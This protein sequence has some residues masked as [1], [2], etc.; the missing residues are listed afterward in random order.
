M[1]TPSHMMISDYNALVLGERRPPEDEYER[2]EL[3]APE[4]VHET[5]A[6]AR[7]YELNDAAPPG[8]VKPGSV[9]E[10]EALDLIDAGR[11]AELER[12]RKRGSR[13]RRIV[14]RRIEHGQ[15]IGFVS[16]GRGLGLERVVL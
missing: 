4:S 14:M 8:Y 5:L 15:H 3:P 9:E 16:R 13:G 10:T 12:D 7:A 1:R 11:A 2:R 6:M